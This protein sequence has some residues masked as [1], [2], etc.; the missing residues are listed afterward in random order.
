MSDAPRL[1]AGPDLRESIAAASYNAMAGY[2]ATSDQPR[3]WTDLCRRGDPYAGRVRDGF[4]DLAD[5]LL[6]PSGPLA[7]LLARIGELE[8]ALAA[9]VKPNGFDVDPDNLDRARSTLSSALA[10]EEG[11]ASQER[12]K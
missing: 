7:P 2:F 4:L 6:A 5:A 11:S 1:Q 9:I 3:I 12:G 10:K 8:A